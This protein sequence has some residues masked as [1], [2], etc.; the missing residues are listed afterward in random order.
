MDTDY[1]ERK[2]TSGW[3]L[4]EVMEGEVSDMAREI[5]IDPIWARFLLGRGFNWESL[6]ESFFSSPS[7]RRGC[8]GRHP[9]SPGYFGKRP[10]GQFSNRD[11]CGSG[12][13][14]D[15]FRCDVFAVLVAATTSS[16][17]SSCEA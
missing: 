4:P 1:G 15:H 8:G 10:G 17:G 16:Q 9:G 11:I 6:S 14:R 7:S 2:R 5:G 12:R 13:G 3:L